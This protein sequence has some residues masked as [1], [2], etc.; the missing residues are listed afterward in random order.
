M[1]TKKHIELL[2]IRAAFI[3]QGSSLNAYCR[4]HSISRGNAEK[5]IKGEWKGV[6]GRLVK[7]KIYDA[8]QEECSW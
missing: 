8:A 1:T 3:R 4:E 6:K 2:K 5:A 7:Q